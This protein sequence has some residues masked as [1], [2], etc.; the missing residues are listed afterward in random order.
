MTRTLIVNADDFGL[1]TAVSEGIL[2]AHQHG[3][4]TSTSILVLAPAFATTAPWLRDVDRLGIGAHLA[5][6]G[7]DPPLLTA[8]E[9]PSLVDARGYLP[10]SW[11]QLLP[12]VAARRIDL[13]DVEREWRAQLDAITA[14]GLAVDHLDSHQ[15]VHVFPGLCDV[16]I[17]LAKARSIPAVRVTRSAAN[18]PVGRVMRRLGNRFADR[19]ASE[20][21]LFPGDSAGLDEAGALDEAAVLTALV[22]LAG[23]GAAVVE[24][25]GHPGNEADPDR[26]R[27]DWNYRWGAELDAL[28]ALSVRN[29]INRHGFTLGTYRDLLHVPTNEAA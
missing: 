11:R 21:L 13:A 15:H 19:A 7:E 20:G 18:G 1:T 17:R 14:E 6:V 3:V 2:R 22:R 4:V 9:I 28:C 23:S 5:V 25:S 24:L 16:A 27:Y 8:R 10:T 12:R 29:A 26:H